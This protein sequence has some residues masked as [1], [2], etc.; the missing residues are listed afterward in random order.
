MY[1]TSRFACLD[2][3]VQFA[4]ERLLVSIQKRGAG[5]IV[6]VDA[7]IFCGFFFWKKTNWN[8]NK[9]SLIL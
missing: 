8:N 7:Q 1:R 5:T 6:N 4:P 9:S 3:R 2:I